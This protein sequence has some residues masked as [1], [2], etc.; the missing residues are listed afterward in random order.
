M[1][2]WLKK[3]FIPEEGNNHRPHIL[4]DHATRKLIAIV[5]LVEVFT[6]LL[7]TLTHINVVGNMAAVLPAVLADLTNSERQS[8]SLPT[9]LVNPLLNLAAQMK[10]ND[11]ATKGYFAHTSPEGITPWYWIEKAGYK[12]QYAGEN[13][14]INFSDSKDV[15][16]AWM[17]SPTHRA[18]IVK[19]NY[20]E[21]GTG[22]ATGS[23]EGKETVFVAQVYANPAPHIATIAPEQI[24]P[25]KAP[26]KVVNKT[27]KI[28]TLPVV[29]EKKN[30]EVLGTET[31]QTPKVG[32]EAPSPLNVT[33]PLPPQP[34]YWQTLFASPRATTNALLFIIDTIIAISLML[35]YFI[36]IRN[37]HRDLIVNGLMVLVVISGIF[38]V[39][40]YLSHSKM[41]I[42][43]SLDYA[44]QSI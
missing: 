26:T 38:I 11:M 2:S 27:A 8:E 20:T 43:E 25:I 10:A 40:S 37:H 9:L 21:V 18:N 39:N 34:T 42:T 28:P 36:K 15:T 23:Y 30:P 32:I 5:L 22:V 29:V 35:Y 12:Y 19:G 6:F 33:A 44:N 17:A 1:F 14:A 24:T 3:H 7:P 41:V 4:R 16:A 31:N 13:L